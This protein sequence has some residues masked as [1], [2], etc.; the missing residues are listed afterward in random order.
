MDSRPRS[1]EEVHTA[2]LSKP[3]PTYEAGVGGVRAFIRADIPSVVTLRRRLFNRSEQSSAGDLALYLDRLFFS[4]V[5][6]DARVPSLVYAD[7]RGEIGGFLG[8]VPRQMLFGGRSLRVAVGT[9]L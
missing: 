8:V 6:A 7:D 9:Q 1:A 4:G 2:A 5:I 3:I